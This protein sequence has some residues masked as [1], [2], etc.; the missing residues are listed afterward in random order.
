MRV[1][2]TGHQDLG[3]PDDVAWVTDRLCEQIAEDTLASGITSLAV[4]ADQLFASLLARQQ[5]PFTAI[6]PCRDYERTFSTAQ[7][8]QRYRSLLAQAVAVTY[9]PHDEP[10]EQAFWEAG[11]KLVEDSNYLIA[12]WNGLPARGLGGTA[13]VVKYCLSTGKKVVHINPR[14]HRVE[15][16]SGTARPGQQ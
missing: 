14:T 10:S 8:Q 3:S 7:D 9:L 11:K 13:D 15:E 2:I 4:G 1:G 12:V 5:K 6:I 16:L